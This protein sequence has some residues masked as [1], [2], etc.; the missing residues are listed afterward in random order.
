MTPS[1][2]QF[3]LLPERAHQRGAA[4]HGTQSIACAGLQVCQV[5]GTPIGQLVMLQVSPDVLGRIQLRGVR[6]QRRDLHSTIERIQVFAY[7]RAAMDRRSIPD[8]QQ[9]L[10]DLQPQGVQELDNLRPL[11]GAQIPSSS[12]GPPRFQP[13][14]AHTVKFSTGI[15]RR[16][17]QCGES[18]KGSQRDPCA[19]PGNDSCRARLSET[20][21]SY[22]GGSSR[23]S[24]VFSQTCIASGSDCATTSI[25]C[26]GDASLS[27]SVVT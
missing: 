11:D 18:R 1:D 14:R 21:R 17:S 7:Q 25:T 13:V 10:T 26:I 5:L 15:N 12:A 6:R 27:S 23:V 19:L 9:G 2:C 20:H 4:L 22:A 16:S 24:F 3:S 8:D